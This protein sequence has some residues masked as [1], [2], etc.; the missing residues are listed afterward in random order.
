MIVSIADQDRWIRN[1]VP[2][3]DSHTRLFCFP[4]AGGSA[5]YYYWLSAALAPRVEVRAIQ[6]PGRLD[7]RVEPSLQNIPDL[8]D[9]A[10]DALR[11]SLGGPYAFFGHS[12]GAVVAYEVARRLAR[13]TGGGPRWLFV[14]GRRA[15]T[16]HRAASVHLRSDAS[17]VRELRTLGAT[18]PRWLD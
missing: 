12:M 9:F 18:E 16:R 3:P 13:K 8:A 10:C 7:R 4:Y 15:P 14:S 5:S 17:L 6:Y 11:N 2:S 1:L